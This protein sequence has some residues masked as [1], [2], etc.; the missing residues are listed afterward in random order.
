[1]INELSTESISHWYHGC[2]PSSPFSSS[3]SVLSV[4]RPHPSNLNHII[5]N[6]FSFTKLRDFWWFSNVTSFLD[7]MRSSLILIAFL[8][9]ACAAPLSTNHEEEAKKFLGKLFVAAK[10]GDRALGE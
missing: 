10:N 7:Q 6:I 2:V 4:T 8:G 1:M 3:S 5:F 9:L